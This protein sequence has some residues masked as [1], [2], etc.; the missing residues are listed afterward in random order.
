MS[1]GVS[2]LKCVAHVVA[3]TPSLICEGIYEG[4]KYVDKKI[5]DYGRE[6]YEQGVR[7]G[8]KKGN[9]ETAKKLAE[10]ME[11][12]DGLKAAALAVAVYVAN[13]DGKI[14]EDE[15][16]VVEAAL[17][18]ADS[19]FTNDNLKD[20]FAKALDEVNAGMDFNA[21][22]SK[23]LNSLE[24]V[25]LKLLDELVKGVIEADDEVS[26]QEKSFLQNEWKPYLEKRG[27][28]H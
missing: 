8:V 18:A 12:E 14:N 23:Y 19:Q 20:K 24:L 9:I 7:H 25:D 17:G 3:P 21:I 15:V 2:F 5:D 10:R 1:F 16:A 28:K 22:K 11:Y 13:L 6:K 4:Y 27:L 26:R